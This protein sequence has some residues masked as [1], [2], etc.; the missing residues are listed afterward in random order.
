MKSSNLFFKYYLYLFMFFLL[1]VSVFYFVLDSFGNRLPRYGDEV[2]YIDCGLRYVSGVP[3]YLCNFEH[4]PFAKYFIGF[5]HVFG[6]DRIVFRLLCFCCCFLVFLIVYRFCGDVFLGFSCFLL[7]VLDSLFVNVFRFLLLDPV[8]LFFSFLALYL[9]LEKRYIFSAVFLGL[10]IASKFSAI[11]IALGIFILFICL[12]DYRKM[13][14][15]FS[16]VFIVYISTY[17]ADFSLGWDAVVR[18]HIDMFR[19][20]SWRHGFSLPIAA[21]GFLKLLAKV[22]VW[23]YVG[24]LSIVLGN[25]SGTYVVLNQSF[26]YLDSIELYTVVGVGMGSIVWYLF[27]PLLLYTTYLVLVGRDLGLCSGISTSFSGFV[28]FSWLS[29]LNIVAGPIDWYYVYVLP[30]LYINTVVALERIARKKTRL[31]IA[32]VISIQFITFI[33]TILGYIPFKYVAIW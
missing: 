5:L 26:V 8:S 11:P 15:Y 20:M 14:L 22:E 13:F 6:V 2:Y 12:R 1:V 32:L 28:M 17:V 3:P 30:F 29:L 23:R 24:E 9:F 19:Y 27:I 10:G 33:A 21:N 31:V 16:I 4:P 25:V 18:H 7:L